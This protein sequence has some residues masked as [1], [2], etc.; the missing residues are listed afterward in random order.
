MGRFEKYE[1]TEILREVIKKLK[2]QKNAGL[3]AGIM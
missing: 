3:T 1:D 2:K